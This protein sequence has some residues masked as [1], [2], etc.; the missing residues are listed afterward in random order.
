MTQPAERRRN[1]RLRQS[2]L[3]ACRRGR[4]GLQ[5]RVQHPQKVQVEIC[6]ILESNWYHI[7][8]QFPKCVAPTQ[9]CR[10]P[11]YGNTRNM[12]KEGQE[13]RGPA[14]AFFATGA[15]AVTIGMAWGIAMAAS[16][17]H[18]LAG[19]HAHLNLVG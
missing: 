17:D 9:T 3:A 10:M 12:R 1:R 5:K 19:A 13:M 15:V 2:D 14:L 4:A 18:S 6:K 16:G 11:Q 7:I 8:N